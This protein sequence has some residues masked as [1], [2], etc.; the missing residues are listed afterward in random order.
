[1][2]DSLVNFVHLL[3]TAIW[4]GGAIFIKAI[5]E[6]STRTIDPREAGKLQSA[7]AKRFTITAWTS[8]ILL[9]ITGFM[10]TPPGMLLDLSSDVGTILT[11]KHLLIIVVILIG[12]I[13]GF[14]AVPRLQRAA[15]APGSP[16]SEEFLKAN[17]QLLRLSMISTITGIAIVFCASFLW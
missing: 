11:I 17:K 14:V 7:I 5:L 13:I 15:P 10:K 4:L 16:P 6:P 8:I 9:I 12:I 3:A 1:M 2:W